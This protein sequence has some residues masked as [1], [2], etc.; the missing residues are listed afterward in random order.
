MKKPLAALN[1][2]KGGCSGGR[3]FARA[4]S[5]RGGTRPGALILGVVRNPL[6][7]AVPAARLVFRLAGQTGGGKDPFWKLE[8]V[9][10]LP[11]AGSI[12]A[13]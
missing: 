1:A 6:P 3:A 11:E 2:G 7:G 4:S 12:A 8:K 10:M 13:L 9:K 5:Q